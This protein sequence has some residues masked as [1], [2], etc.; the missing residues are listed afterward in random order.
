MAVKLLIA[1]LAVLALV[2]CGDIER[3][4]EPSDA[5][6]PASATAIAAAAHADDTP[7]ATAITEPRPAV[8]VIEQHLAYGESRDSNLIGF[9][10]MPEDA[11]EPLPGIVMIH[12]WWGLNDNVR[13]VARR[14]AGEGYVVLAVDLYGGQVAVEPLRAEQLMGTVMSAREE[15]RANLRQAYEYLERY[16]LA[17]AIGSVGWCLGGAWSLQT[18]LML[19]RDLD[20]VV[21]YYGDVKVDS[22]Q[23]ADLQ[24]P[25]LGLFAE[26]DPT[27]PVADVEVFRETLIAAGRSA[28]IVI[29]PG[30]DHAFANPSGDAYDAA[31]AED[32]WARTVEFLRDNLKRAGAG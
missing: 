24:M 21:M 22:R 8:P 3:A 17:P 27:I 26:F 7:A 18:A 19:P 29:Y 31:A 10:A 16:A 30:T 14:L 13:D 25:I 6:A 32:A 2:G 23:L 28:D 11:A 4:A 5:P 20:A 1:P 15:T 12:E 9:L